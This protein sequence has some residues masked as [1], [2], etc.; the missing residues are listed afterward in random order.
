MEEGLVKDGLYFVYILSQLVF[1]SVWRNT[2]SVV[3]IIGN[4]KDRVNISI[5]KIVILKY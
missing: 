2:L 1:T 5:H 4:C 3:F